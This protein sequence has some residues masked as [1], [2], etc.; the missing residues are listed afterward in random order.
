MTY[1][2]AVIVK[3]VLLLA[4]SRLRYRKRLLFPQ[5]LFSFSTTILLETV[6]G[7]HRLLFIL[8]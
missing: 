2:N 5:I 1:C 6:N 4:V 7:F 3:P 8:K